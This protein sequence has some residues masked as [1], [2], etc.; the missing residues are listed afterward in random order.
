[1]RLKFSEVKEAL[2]RNFRIRNLFGWILI[3]CLMRGHFVFAGDETSGIIPVK[4][5]QSLIV[6]W[7]GRLVRQDI[8]EN[9]VKCGLE[10]QAEKEKCKLDLEK[11][12]KIC[13][14]ELKTKDDICNLRV[15]A[16]KYERDLLLKY[17]S[18][19]WYENWFIQL[20]FMGALTIGIVW[21][22]SYAYR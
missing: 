22:V 18:K 3:F 16:V 12:E 2:K 14:E 15:D 20:I 8:Y 5:G 1:M 13:E 17:T 4:K 10:L 11:S 21:G 6:P 7:E 9:M 19:K